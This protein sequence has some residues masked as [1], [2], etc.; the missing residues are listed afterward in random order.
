MQRAL[1]PGLCLAVTLRYLATGDSY[2]SLQYG[3]R[4]AHSTISLIVP[5][6]CEAVI[7]EYINEVMRCRG[8]L[9]GWRKVCKNFSARWDFHNT[10]GALDGKH[11]PICCPSN[12]GSVY[13]YYKRFHTIVLLA[14]VYANY[15]ILYLDVGASG[16]SSDGGIF[17][18]SSLFQALNKNLVA[19]RQP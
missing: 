17:K 2:T 11:V 12:A 9:E 16:N 15:K 19:I 8:T 6:T 5:E 14:L 1:E 13:F 3:F 18:D 4:V 7:Q 10:F